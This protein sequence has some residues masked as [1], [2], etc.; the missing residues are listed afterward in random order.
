ARGG[1]IRERGESGVAPDA[2]GGASALR[3]S[4]PLATTCAL[5]APT[6]FAQRSP[7]L[8]DIPCRVGQWRRVQLRGN[9]RE[10]SG[11]ELARLSLRMAASTRPEGGAGGRMLVRPEKA[12][13]IRQLLIVSRSQQERYAYLRYV[14]DSESGEGILDRRVGGRGSRRAGGARATPPGAGRHRAPP[15]GAAG[16]GRDGRPPGVRL[17][18]R[19]IRGEAIAREE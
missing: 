18:A 7:L 17:G 8:C 14:F 11:Q 19:E 5:T 13:V 1:R 10:R 16:A 15:R 12:A 6:E 4:L 2:R 3:A 9:S